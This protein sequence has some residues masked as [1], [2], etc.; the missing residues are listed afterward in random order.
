MRLE[1]S[2]GQ[3]GSRTRNLFVVAQIAGSTLFLSIAALMVQSFVTTAG[4]NPGFETGHLLVVELE[5]ADFGYDAPRSHAFFEDLVARVR[6]LPGVEHAAIADRVPFYVGFR[7]LTKISAD[8]TDCRTADCRS[9]AVYAIG[10][11]HFRALGVRLIAGREFTIADV[12]AGDGAIVSDTLAAKLWPGGNAV[13]Q[14]IREGPESRVRQIVGVAANVAHHMLN[15]T[16]GDYIYRPIAPSEFGD[17]VTLIVRTATPSAPFISRVQQQ[18]QALDPAMPPGSA[19]TM[20]QRMELPLWP[21]RTAAAF[22]TT[23]GALALLLATVGLFGMTY[24][25]VGQRTREFGI[26]AALGATR[27]RVA[28]LVL[29]EGLRL[30]IPGV[31]LGMIGAGVAGRALSSALF[32]V[33]AGDP[34]NYIAVALVQTGVALAACLL[35]A[36]RATRADPALALRAE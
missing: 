23:C 7:R 24:L 5:P 35:P 13:G 25:A 29:G 11:D 28:R 4:R 19:K 33:H 10:A 8:G 3:Q 30:A 1:V 31:A 26:R 27:L 14:W 9:A 12:K 17:R 22:S 34:L 16:P 20:E 6:A 2:L 36:V 15:E 18:I 21:V 32:Q